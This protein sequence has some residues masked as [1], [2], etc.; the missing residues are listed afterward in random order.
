M[1][2][3]RC[4]EFFKKENTFYKEKCGTVKKIKSAKN[5]TIKKVSCK[6]FSSIS[7]VYDSFFGT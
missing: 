6:S 3:E 4:F 2:S 1:L 5:V 7:T